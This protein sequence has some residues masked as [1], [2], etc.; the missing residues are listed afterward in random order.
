MIHWQVSGDEGVAA[1]SKRRGVAS[2]PKL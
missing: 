1:T 2:T